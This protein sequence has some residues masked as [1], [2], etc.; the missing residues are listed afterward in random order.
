M[1]SF[2]C[3]TVTCCVVLV[4]VGYVAICKTAL[5]F[6]EEVVVIVLASFPSHN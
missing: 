3:Q 4:G 1:F 2:C 6:Q 5:C